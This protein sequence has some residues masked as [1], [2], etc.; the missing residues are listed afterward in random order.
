[1]QK[2]SS[3]NNRKNL[4][5]KNYDYASDGVYFVTICVNNRE[6]LF[7]DI[8]D[9]MMCLNDVGNDLIKNYGNEI[10]NHTSKFNSRLARL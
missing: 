1:M 8:V 5:L 2:N 7:G 3:Y 6:N 10:K 4:R 9:G